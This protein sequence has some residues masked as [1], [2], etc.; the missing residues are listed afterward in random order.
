MTVR[1]RYLPVGKILFRRR[2]AFRTHFEIVTPLDAA[3]C[4]QVS[5][6][7]GP[8]F[9]FWELQDLSPKTARAAPP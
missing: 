7:T 8:E 6:Q 4:I 1:Y 5:V 2:A 9:P 3:P